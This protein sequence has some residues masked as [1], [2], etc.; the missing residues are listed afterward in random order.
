MP[1]SGAATTDTNTELGGHSEDATKERP[2]TRPHFLKAHTT[3]H[4]MASKQQP[5]V[6]LVVPAFSAHFQ[7]AS[8]VRQ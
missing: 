4:L 7:E 5:T 8:A 3:S 2:P 1:V 6:V